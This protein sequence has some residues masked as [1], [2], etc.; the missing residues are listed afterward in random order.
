[1]SFHNVLHDNDCVVT[2][3]DAYADVLKLSFINIKD[4]FAIRRGARGGGGGGILLLIE[5]FRMRMWTSHARL[6]QLA[7]GTADDIF[8]YIELKAP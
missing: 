5:D 4:K 2:P 7:Y 3:F 6:L 1:M 8:F